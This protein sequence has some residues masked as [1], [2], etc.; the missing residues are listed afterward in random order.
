M[1][2]GVCGGA[3]RAEAAATAGYDYLE[4]SV[5]G[6]LKPLEEEEAF[7]AELEKTKALPLPTPVVNCF[8]PGD[9]KITGPEAD[10]NRLEEYVTV[11]F[12]RARKANVDIIVFGSGG[13]RRIPDGFDRDEAW[14][15]LKEFCQMLS[16]I[17]HAH[18]VCVVIEPLSQSECNVF[19]TVGE[20]ARMVREVDHPGLRLL[21]DG[22]HWGKDKD[23][24]DDLVEA[25]PL[26]AHAHIATYENRRTPGAEPCDFTAFF[27]A[28]KRGGYTGRMSVEGKIEDPDAELGPGLELMK[29]LS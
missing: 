4:N 2:F 26:L 1:K 6:L 11:V 22:Y 5:A 24:V 3:A 8:V 17:A 7:L 15:Q 10:L 18:D 28:L 12:K 25:C 13:A 29:S 16:P 23:S 14:Q 21:V 19:T 20:C 27:D 9:I